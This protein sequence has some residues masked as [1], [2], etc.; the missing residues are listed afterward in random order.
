MAKKNVS[1][2][3]DLAAELAVDP[4]EA[5][6]LTES[7]NDLE[8]FQGDAFVRR[9]PGR[10]P[11]GNAKELISVRLSRDVVAKLREAG[12][13]W[14]SQ[15]DTLLRGALGLSEEPLTFAVYVAGRRVIDTPAGD[16]IADAKGDSTLPD[17]RT[18]P[19]LETY[20]RARGA[21]I[22]AVSAARAVWHQYCAANERR[23]KL[24][25]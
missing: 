8:L 3:P 9:G 21:S 25:G 16:F 18:W 5:P 1:G 13:G 19:E 2:S 20:L 24:P 22:D 14:Q 10:P 7:P 17:V 6:I 23:V 4:D 12:P 11:T 15:I